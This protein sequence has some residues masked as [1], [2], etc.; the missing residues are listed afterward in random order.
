MFTALA[1]MQ[2][3][4]MTDKT[5]FPCGGGFNY[6]GLRIKGH[7]GADPLIPAIKGIQQLFTFHTPSWR[8]SINTLAIRPKVWMEWKKIM[9]VSASEHT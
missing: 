7:G 2:M 1:G 5:I 9:K 8:W 3:G 6:Q 4:V